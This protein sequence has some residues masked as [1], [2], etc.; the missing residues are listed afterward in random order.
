VIGA[1]KKRRLTEHDV[2]PEAACLEG[3]GEP[4]VFDRHSRRDSVEVPLVECRIDKALKR[5]GFEGL[6]P[7]LRLPGDQRNLQ[8]TVVRLVIRQQD[9]TNGSAVQVLDHQCGG[10]TKGSFLVQPIFDPALHF[11]QRNGQPAMRPATRPV[12]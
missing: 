2:A 1:V 10:S 6:V 4:F 5:V 11:R 9:R 12:K 8:R 7:Y 3:A